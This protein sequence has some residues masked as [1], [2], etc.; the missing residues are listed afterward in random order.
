MQKMMN[1]NYPFSENV[2]EKPVIAV[3]TVCNFLLWLNENRS[4]G[5]IW[6]QTRYQQEWKTMDDGDDGGMLVICIVVWSEPH[7][8]GVGRKKSEMCLFWFNPS[9]QSATPQLLKLVNNFKSKCMLMLNFFQHDNFGIQ[10][11]LLRLQNLIVS[12]NVWYDWQVFFLKVWDT[13]V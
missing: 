5:I 2:F 4:T 8:T 13:K 6:C 3:V 10:V 11:I 1:I 7:L 9:H 12:A